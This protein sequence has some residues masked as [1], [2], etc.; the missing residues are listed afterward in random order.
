[1]KKKNVVVNTLSDE[2]LTDIEN[3]I[4]DIGANVIEIRYDLL[5]HRYE[6][7][8]RLNFKQRHQLRY[9][10]KSREAKIIFEA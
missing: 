7:Y 10:I 3:L 1:M 5:Y 2:V 4:E 6:L 8:T 9:F